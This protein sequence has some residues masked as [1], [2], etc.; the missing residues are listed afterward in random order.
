MSQWSAGLTAAALIPPLG[1]LL[2][3]KPTI[4]AALWLAYPSAAAFISGLA[5]LI[6]SLAIAP[7]WPWGWLATL[8][9]VPH[10]TP[11]LAYAGGPL[12]LLALL[13]WRRPE[14][15]LLAA[16]A[17]TPQTLM[18]YET[19]PL[20]LVPR[21][22]LQGLTLALGS[23]V[24]LV[25]SYAFSA[26][27]VD[28]VARYLEERAVMGRWIVWAMYLPCLVMILRRPNL[29]EAPD[30]VRRFGLRLSSWGRRVLGRQTR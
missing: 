24:A 13:R 4:G 22:N 8:N 11:P 17:C 30:D 23:W 6:L 12:L 1:F 9:E 14:A 27:Q 16:L 25:A 19:L 20:F 10:V 7:S 26:V 2:S 28:P 21:T 5:F 18:F 29:A 15:R 3:C